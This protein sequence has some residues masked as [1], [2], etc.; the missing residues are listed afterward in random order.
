MT[1]NNWRNFLIDL[2]APGRNILI[3]NVC[4]NSEQKEENVFIL[5]FSNDYMRILGQKNM[6]MRYTF[7]MPLDTHKTLKHFEA[8]FNEQ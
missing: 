6:N 8:F 7:W 5:C 3:W 4:V 2:P 1:E